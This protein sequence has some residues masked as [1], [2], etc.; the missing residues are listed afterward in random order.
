VIKTIRAC[1][2]INY[3]VYVS[4]DKSGLISNGADLGR[5]ASNTMKGLPFK[6]VKA[7][8]VDMFP[9]CDGLELVVLFERIKS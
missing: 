4:C 3:L 6:P 7:V 2:S 9:H 5:A 8:G 1:S